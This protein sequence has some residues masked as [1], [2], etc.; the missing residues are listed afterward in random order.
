MIE[1]MRTR[2]LHRTA[3]LL[4]AAALFVPGASRAA[5]TGHDNL[6]KSVTAFATAIARN[7]TAIAASNGAATVSREDLDVAG[8]ES[9]PSDGI[10]Y[11]AATDN[12]TGVSGN[13]T[14]R[15]TFKLS[16][17]RLDVSVNRVV[18]TDR[19]KEALRAWNDAL[20]DLK[21]EK[22]RYEKEAKSLYKEM[23]SN[24][25]AE[26]R[27]ELEYL[28][29]QGATKAEKDAAKADYADALKEAKFW[30]KA[31]LSGLEKEYLAR[32]AELGPRP[33][34]GERKSR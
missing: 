28:N 3:S 33:A 32:V 18:C 34:S 2:L 10:F 29:D 6:R 4:L 20:K 12:V 30:Y 13:R 8:S 7:A 17:T 25:K 26:Y 1:T 11:D 16:T 15:A 27:E 31:V 23:L 5:A 9:R 22:R 21:A 24:I 14:C 19:G